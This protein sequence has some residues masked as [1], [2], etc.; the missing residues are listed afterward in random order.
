MRAV[1][2]VQDYYNLKIV[3]QGFETYDKD[4]KKKNKYSLGINLEFFNFCYRTMLFTKKKVFNHKQQTYE[5][6][7][8]MHN[9]N[10]LDSKISDIR[11]LFK[12]S[13]LKL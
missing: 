3:C 5:F 13:V 6:Y 11:V 12:M 7:V 10:L 1:N 2:D 4:Q 9:V 8:Q